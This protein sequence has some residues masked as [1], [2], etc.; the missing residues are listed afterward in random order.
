MGTAWAALARQVVDQ[1]DRDVR[2]VLDA[3]RGLL[4]KSGSDV[5][6]HA[7]FGEQVTAHSKEVAARQGHVAAVKSGVGRL[8]VPYRW[9]SCRR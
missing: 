9:G 1:L 3:R 2:L 6:V 5:H 4:A 7:V 8:R